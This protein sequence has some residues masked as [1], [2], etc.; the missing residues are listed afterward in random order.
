[1]FLEDEYVIDDD[2]WT[3]VGHSWVNLITG[4]II[5]MPDEEESVDEPCLSE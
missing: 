4:K 5:M 1:V 2:G 3:V